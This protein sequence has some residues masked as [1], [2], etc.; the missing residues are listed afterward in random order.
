VVR[1]LT[2]SGNAIYKNGQNGINADG[3][4]G[5]TI[6][7]N[8]I[9]GNARHGIELYQI[10]ALG[11]STGNLIVN[12]TI[13]QSSS[14]GGY[15]I[16]ID[17][18]AYDNQSAA[19]TP[20][21]C[22]TSTADTSTGNVAFDNILIGGAGPIATVSSADLAASTNITAA[23]SGLF[24]SSGSYVLATGG[25]GDGTGVATFSGQSAP[26]TSTGGHDIGAFAFVH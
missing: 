18:C 4:E 13:D 19:P 3:L 1:S 6:V 26:A 15:A 14:S 8:V 10:D 25:P 22:S 17:K 12:N 24:Q 2:I 5:S 9:Y 7:N 16:S 11:G 21:G 23:T 20:A